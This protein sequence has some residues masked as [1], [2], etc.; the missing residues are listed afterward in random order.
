MGGRAGVLNRNYNAEWAELYALEES[1]NL[2]RD[3]SWARV[4]F[5]SDCA[6]LVNRLRRP[7]V[8][9]STFGHRIRDLLSNLN[10]R[11]SFN[12]K[13]APRWCNKAADQLCS[14][15]LTNN[16]TETFDMDYPREIHNIVLND[17]IN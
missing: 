3:N 5:E 7:N 6:S 17:D 15:A 16:C 14:W 12:F 10:P 9:L 4:E 2:A 8:D 13:W 11:F 1:I